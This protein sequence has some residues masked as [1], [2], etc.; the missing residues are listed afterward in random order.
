[1]TTFTEQELQ[2]LTD[3]LTRAAENTKNM[4]STKNHK[5]FNREILTTETAK[6]YIKHPKLLEMLNE[7][8]KPV[9]V[10]G[11]TGIGKTPLAK[12]IYNQCL[13]LFPETEVLY[14]N[15]KTLLDKLS[16]FDLH[17][18]SIFYALCSRVLIWDEFAKPINWHGLPARTVSNFAYMI[19][20][21][22]EHARDY[23]RQ[24]ILFFGHCRPEEVIQDASVVR[25]IYELVEGR[26]IGPLKNSEC[27]R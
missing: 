24:T 16:E 15:E 10:Y 17:L 5:R 2:E 25:R 1:M 22:Y 26:V 7:S 21:L 23:S 6:K 27:V 20:C 11:D 12:T 18:E 9:I 19:D 8:I 13:D 14:F 3:V 4:I